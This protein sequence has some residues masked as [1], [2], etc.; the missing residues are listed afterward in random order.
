MEKKKLDM[1][2]VTKRYNDLM[3]SVGCE[4]CTIGTRFSENTEGWNLRDMVAECDYLLSCYFEP[5]HCRYED[6]LESK[7]SY[8]IWL[9]EKGMLKR[10]IDRLAPYVDGMVCKVNHCSNYDNAD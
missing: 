7:E 8:K 9:S 1:Q 6:R 2:K 4:H 10:F 3:Y 5:G